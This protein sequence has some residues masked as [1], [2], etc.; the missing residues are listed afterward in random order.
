MCAGIE[1]AGAVVM[2]ARVRL[3]S[4]RILSVQASVNLMLGVRAS[5]EAKRWADEY[6]HEDQGW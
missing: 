3:R 2:P 5:A 1:P 4:W 6:E